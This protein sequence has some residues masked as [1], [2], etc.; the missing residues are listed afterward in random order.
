MVYAYCKVL[1]HRRVLILCVYL[2]TCLVVG[3][4]VNFCLYLTASV[5]EDKVVFVEVKLL[6][7]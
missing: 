5:E 3:Y 4:K 6:V 7:S 2:Q 1:E